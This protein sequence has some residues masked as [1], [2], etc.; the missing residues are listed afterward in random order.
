MAIRIGRIGDS[1]LEEL[2]YLTNDETIIRYCRY[3]STCAHFSDYMF[4]GEL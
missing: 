2:R 4:Y 1:P 3:F